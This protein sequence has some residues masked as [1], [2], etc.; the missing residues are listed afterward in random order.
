LSGL[1]DRVYRIFGWRLLEDQGVSDKERKQIMRH[2][3]TA[4]YEALAEV[5]NEVTEDGPK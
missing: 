4:I 1:V 2:F 3:N 5:Y